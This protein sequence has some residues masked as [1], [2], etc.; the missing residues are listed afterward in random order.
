METEKNKITVETTMAAKGR[1]MSFDFE[2][3]CTAVQKHQFIEYVMA[4]GREVKILFSAGDNTT[5]ITEI[6]DVENIH[7]ADVQKNGWQ[8]ILDNFKKYTEANQ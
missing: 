6:F 2:G 7:L 3:V 4:D 1:S 5:Q 8:S